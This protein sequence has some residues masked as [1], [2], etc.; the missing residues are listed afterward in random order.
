[1]V[2]LPASFLFLSL[3]SFAHMW[4]RLLQHKLYASNE[5]GEMMHKYMYKLSCAR[6]SV[7]LR[8]H[9]VLHDVYSH[10]LNCTFLIRLKYRLKS[11]NSTWGDSNVC[12][13]ELMWNEW[14]IG[15]HFICEMRNVPINTHR[16][17]L[18]SCKFRL[19]YTS[20]TKT[21]WQHSEPI[22]CLSE[23]EL[24][25]FSCLDRCK[26][27]ALAD[28]SQINGCSITLTVC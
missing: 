18:F 17:I 20:C 3:R 16:S 13:G 15:K 9:T 1:M 28:S 6:Q 10:Q 21:I 7:P 25:F 11:W 19:A 27:W 24:V 12:M 14:K 26:S 2:L 5:C 8:V 23:N 22:Y 4:V